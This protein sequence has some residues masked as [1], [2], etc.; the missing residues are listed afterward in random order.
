MKKLRN[1][2]AMVVLSLPL[3]T[4]NAG[5]LIADAAPADLNPE[6]SV[7]EWCYIYWGGYW[8]LVPC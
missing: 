6:Q 4:A 7:H 8:W 3:L 2:L 1:L 5:T